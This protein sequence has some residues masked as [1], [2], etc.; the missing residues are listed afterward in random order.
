MKKIFLVPIVLTMLCTNTSAQ[1]AVTGFNKSPARCTTGTC[2]PKTSSTF[3]KT[4][5]KKTKSGQKTEPQVNQQAIQQKVQ[6]KV[7]N[8]PPPLPA[9]SKSSTVSSST[10]AKGLLIANEEVYDD[11][12]PGTVYQ[13]TIEILPEATTKVDLSSIDINRIV[14]PADIKDV[15]YSKEKGL[16]V[17]I[18]G[19]NAF[20]KFTLAKEDSRKVYAA[21]P[22]EV[23]VVCGDDVYT[24]IAYPKRIPAQVVKL[25]KGKLDAVKK[26]MGMFN[27]VPFEK[28]VMTI[29]KTIFTDAMPDSFNVTVINKPFNVFQQVDLI[30]KRIITVEG[31]G[32]KVKEYTAQAKTDVYLKEKDFLR[33]DLTT[34][35]IAVSMSALNLKKDETSRILMV[36]QGGD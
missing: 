24:M 27:G 12:E 21:I 2:N 25:S 16:N 19:R 17:R 29:L 26:N 14:C 13:N 9:P 18:Q 33:T 32:I 6:E 34:K 35:T 4:E 22:V 31:E 28:K 5:D 15:V 20:F 10:P 11:T 36:E 8:A 7:Q 1:V 23:Y 3:Y 30:L